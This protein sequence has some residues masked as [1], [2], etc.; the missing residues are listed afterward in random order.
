FDPLEFIG[1]LAMKFAVDEINNSSIILPLTRIGYEIYDSCQQSEVILEETLKLISDKNDSLVPILCNYTNY[2]SKVIA[3][4]GPSTSKM[5][6]ATGHVLSFFHLPQ[7]SFGDSSEEF[8]E[9]NTYKSFLRTIPSDEFLAQAI[10]QLLNELQWKWIAIV[11]SRETYDDHKWLFQFVYLAS[12]SGICIAHQ[13]YFPEDTNLNASLEVII[14]NIRKSEANVT[15]LFTSLQ[16]TEGFLKAA[17]KFQL[18]MVWI[19]TPTWSLSKTIQQLPGIDRIG[20]VIGFSVKSKELPGFNDYVQTVL[21]LKDFS[22][23]SDQESKSTSR[24]F[25]QNQKI[26]RDL[27][28]ICSSCGSLL[29]EYIT[30]GLD[31]MTKNVAYR[32]YVAV[33]CIAQALHSMLNCAPGLRCIDPSD[34][35]PWQLLNQLKG[36]NFTVGNVNINFDLYGNPNIGYDILT[37]RNTS[38]PVV[39][40]GEFLDKLTIRK[41]LIKWHSEV[42]PQS[43][44]SR[45]CSDGQIKISKDF[46]SCCF[47]CVTCPEGTFSNGTEC[48]S[49]PVSQWSMSGSKSCQPPTFSFLTW[50]NYYVI[51]IVVF[52]ALI[53]LHVFAIVQL[54]FRHRSTPVIRASGG[55]MCFLI[56]LGFVCLNVSI[57]FYIGEP[58]NLICQIRYVI[59]NISFTLILGPILVK[60]LQLFFTSNTSLPWLQ[61]IL[62]HGIWIILLSITLGQVIL[63]VLYIKFVEMLSVDLTS[64]AISSLQV[65]VSC[66]YEPLLQFGLMLSYN[67]LLILLCFICCFMAEKPAHQYHMARDTTVAMLT[68]IIL[69]VIFIPTY[70]SMPVTFKSFIQM[71]FILGSS[72]GTLSSLFFPKCYVLVYKKELNNCDYFRAYLPKATKE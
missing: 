3:V 16:E 9:K 62:S 48:S 35:Y 23:Q 71:I 30:K 4:V 50:G 31:P 12:Q 59:L 14:Q 69:W 65:Y 13:A 56:L 60:S 64:T 39:I 40:V 36:Q 5:I 32:V 21:S 7:I 34:I 52:M 46:S 6:S 18:A 47:D 28:T 38:D 57:V 61:W 49:C 41:T 10:L 63:C 42:V 68:L 22:W 55:I 33:Q 53:M 67:F 24:K 8:S 11:G 44:C 54:F 2:K 17:I 58:S 15:I 45:E 51:G 27:Q 37:W 43:S 72:M 1:A 25:Q 20:T 70:V 66:S 19:A 29:Q 26:L